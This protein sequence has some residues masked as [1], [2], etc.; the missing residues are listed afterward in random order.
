[1]TG[2][3]EQ[4]GMT[5]EGEQAGMTGKAEQGGMTQGEQLCVQ[6][7]GRF[8]AEVLRACLDREVVE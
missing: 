6:A 3:A 1:M 7:R 4:A 2:K 5:G 8:L